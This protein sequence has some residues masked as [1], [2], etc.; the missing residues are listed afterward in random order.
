MLMLC[1]ESSRVQQ[2][3]QGTGAHGNRGGEAQRTRLLQPGEEKGTGRDL[4]SVC[5]YLTG[6]GREDGARLLLEVHHN[7]MRGSGH[8]LQH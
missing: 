7:K 5:S 4:T 2:G 8:S 1:S 6:G 3:G